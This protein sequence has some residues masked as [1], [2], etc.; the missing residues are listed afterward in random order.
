MRI[1]VSILIA[2]VVLAGCGAGVCGEP[3]RD[4]E[5]VL[6]IEWQR[7]VDKDGETCDRCGSTG[8]AGCGASNRSRNSVVSFAPLGHSSSGGLF[9]AQVRTARAGITA[10]VRCPT[11]NG[12][13][14]VRM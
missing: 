10:L 13:R 3:D 7:L 5:K 2:L 6:A 12:G 9:L 1:R 11:Q 4:A 8:G 14:H